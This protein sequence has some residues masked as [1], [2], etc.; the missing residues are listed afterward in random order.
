MAPGDD[1]NERLSDLMRAAQDGDKAAYR[2]LL[3]EAAGILRRVFRRRFPSVP[4]ADV[5]DLV[6][7]VLL[8][9][10]AVRATYDPAR[11]F[12][13][14][15]M[16]IARNRAADMARRHARRSARE[17][18]VDVYP[19]TS[20]EDETN[21]VEGF[22]DAEALRQAVAALPQGQR[23]AIELLKLKELSL[24]EAAA[25]SG[26]SV[27]ALKVATHRATRALRLALKARHG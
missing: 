16:A 17:Q 23:T 19:E 27:S 12:L 9:G 24:K 1:R 2:A 22:G 18:A 26:M 21:I 5:E 3:S 6:Q 20:G 25:A 10:H 15:L 13:P 8:S 11:P 14:W 4:L 7:D